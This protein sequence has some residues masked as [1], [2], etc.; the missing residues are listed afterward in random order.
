MDLKTAPLKLG[1]TWCLMPLP[2]TGKAAAPE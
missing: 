2:I 1:S